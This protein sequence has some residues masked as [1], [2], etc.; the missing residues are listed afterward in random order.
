MHGDGALEF[1][2]QAEI[3]NLAWHGAGQDNSSREQLGII[4]GIPRV[5]FDKQRFC[6]VFLGNSRKHGVLG[7]LIHQAV[8]HKAAGQKQAG[9]LH[10]L[11]QGGGQKH[12]ADDGFFFLHQAFQ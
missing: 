12:P 3:E 8:Q 7:G 1:E 4:R 2:G 10:M 9:T 6:A 11:R 5:G